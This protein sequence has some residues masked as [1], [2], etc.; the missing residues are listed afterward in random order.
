[1]EYRSQIGFHKIR[2]LEP[3][4]QISPRSALPPPST[5]SILSAVEGLRTGFSK[6]GI[7]GGFLK[8]ND[9]SDVPP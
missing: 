2:T 1:M 7:E 5:E 9:D 4:L 8:V 3:L 6:G